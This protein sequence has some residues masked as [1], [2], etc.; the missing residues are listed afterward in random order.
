[1]DNKFWSEEKK[2][3]AKKCEDKNTR[4]YWDNLQAIY[5]IVKKY[6]DGSILKNY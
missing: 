6:P 3:V 2:Q 4:L 5:I 1:M